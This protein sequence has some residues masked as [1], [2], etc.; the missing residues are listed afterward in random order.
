MRVF[1]KTEIDTNEYDK[2]NALVFISIPTLN[3]QITTLAQ[4]PVMHPLKSNYCK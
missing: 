3:R 2:S 1:L 4:I